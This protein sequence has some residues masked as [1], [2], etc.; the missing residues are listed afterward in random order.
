MSEQDVKNVPGIGRVISKKLTSIDRATPNMI[1]F[2]SRLVTIEQQVNNIDLASKL[3]VI[4]FNGTNILAELIT[5]DGTGS[6]LDADMLDG[7]HASY[8]APNAHDHDS[9]YYEKS[10]ADSTFLGTH[11]KADDSTLFDG[12]AVS[13]FAPQATTYNKTE[14]DNLID[15]NGFTE[16][17]ATDGWCIMPNGLIMQWGY[18]IST[19]D[20]AETF[21]FPRIFDNDCFNLQIS[22][23]G[24]N[25][26]NT[27]PIGSTNTSTFVIDRVAGSGGSQPFFYFAIGY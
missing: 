10:I 6:G 7:Q 23:I 19:T 8:F 20:N 21:S 3:D 24:S 17:L 27:L 9:R 4:D 1:A 5:V 14:V 25:T 18:A 11:D 12:N 16:S 2:E 26:N 22:R 15:A 13:F